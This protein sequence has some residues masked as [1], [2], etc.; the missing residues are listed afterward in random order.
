MERLIDS[1]HTTFFLTA[2][3]ESKSSIEYA[4]KNVIL[5]YRNAHQDRAEIRAS[6]DENSAY[7]LYI[8]AAKRPLE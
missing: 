7:L 5:G 6:P 3:V 2:Q 4:E 8:Y 1:Q